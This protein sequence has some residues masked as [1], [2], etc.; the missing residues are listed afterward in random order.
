MRLISDDIFVDNGIED[1]A[2][3]LIYPQLETDF[4]LWN[5]NSWTRGHPYDLYQQMREQ[6]PVMWSR[7]KRGGAGFWSV[8][9][10]DDIKACLLYTS[11]SPR[12]RTRSRM[13]SS[14]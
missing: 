8:S 13:P 6:A 11:P 14:A 5:P 4:E 7:M 2:F 10:Y 3:P 9:R 12:D 1:P